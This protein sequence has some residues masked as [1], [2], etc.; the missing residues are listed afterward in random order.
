MCTTLP[1]ARHRPFFRLALCSHHCSYG[2]IRRGQGHVGVLHR[3]HGSNH[4][5]RPQPDLAKS[6]TEHPPTQHNYDATSITINLTILHILVNSAM[7]Q[8]DLEEIH[9][10]GAAKQGLKKFKMQARNSQFT[11]TSS[12]PLP[13]NLRPHN[14]TPNTTKAGRKRARELSQEPESC[15]K[16]Q[17]C[18]IVMSTN[19]AEVPQMIIKNES[20][21]EISSHSRSW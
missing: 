2:H 15:Q 14:S 7:P 20:T 13:S 9:E 6:L 3:I 5:Q 18:A 11:S 16:R 12:E 4:S 10:A 1:V 17:P 21:A 19:D 8:E